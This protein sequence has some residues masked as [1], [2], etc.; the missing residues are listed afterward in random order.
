MSLRDE[1]PMVDSDLE[2]IITVFE[3][4]MAKSQ[5]IDS[6][7]VPFRRELGALSNYPQSIIE[8]IDNVPLPSLSEESGGDP[9][10]VGPLTGDTPAATLTPEVANGDP[11]TPIEDGDDSEDL[12]EKIKDWVSECVPCSGDFERTISSM[13]A[14]FFADIGKE[15]D[16]TLDKTWDK[17]T[18]FEDFLTD[19]DDNTISAFCDI[20][21]ALKDQCV[22]DIKKMIFIL[23]MMLN[24]M[25]KEFSLDLGIVDSFLMS[26]LSPIFNQLGANLDLIDDLALKPIRCV[27]DYIQHQINNGPKMAEQARASIIDPVRRDAY[28]ARGK[29]E[30]ALR[31]NTQRS[32]SRNRIERPSE[33]ELA[34]ERASLEQQRTRLRERNRERLESALSR[35]NNAFDSANDSLSF[36]DKFQGYLTAGTEFLENK[37]DWLLG[38]IEEFIDSGLDRWNDQMIFARKKTDLLTAISIMKAMVETIQNG[39]I[40]CGS[41]SDNMTAEDVARIVRYWQHPSEALE[42]IVEDGNIIT[43]RLPSVPSTEEANDSEAGKSASKDGGTGRGVITGTSGPDSTGEVLPNIVVRRPISSCLKKITTDEADQ[44]SHWIRQLEQEV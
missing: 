17:L 32:S 13:N 16:K 35:A 7:L 18:N 43:R 34:A 14:E 25:Q 12:T 3:K 37:K 9:D 10:V 4:S 36:L 39:D 11:N 22:P 2:L 15:W 19:S 44:V 40:S 24:Q 8:S 21:G 1:N 23:S 38:L 29:I 30:A 31:R 20:G 6:V 28:K 5:D 26:A 33:A 42:I 27:L 41:E